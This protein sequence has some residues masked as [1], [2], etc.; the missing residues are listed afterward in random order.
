MRETSSLW[1]FKLEKDQSRPFRLTV[2]E[3]VSDNPEEAKTGKIFSPNSSAFKI[4]Y[5]AKDLQEFDTKEELIAA[6]QS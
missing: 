5:R 3:A 2:L 1:T 4:E 6:I